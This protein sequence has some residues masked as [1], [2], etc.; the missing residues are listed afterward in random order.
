MSCGKGELHIEATVHSEDLAGDIGGVLRQEKPHDFGHLFGLAKTPHGDGGKQLRI[1][2]A[3]RLVWYVNPT[4]TPLAIN[5]R[6]TAL[7]I[8]RLPPVTTATFPVRD[9][10]RLLRHQVLSVFAQS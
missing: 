8:P 7:P 4:L 5:S 9:M 2:A 6:T 1:L 3:S 10:V